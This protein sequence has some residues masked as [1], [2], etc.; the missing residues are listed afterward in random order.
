MIMLEI[1][2]NLYVFA[3]HSIMQP[4][5]MGLVNA[6]DTQH[7]L[8]GYNVSKLHRHF[9]GHVLSFSCLVFT[10]SLL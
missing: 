9:I 8:K 4:N 3:T 2:V 10:S 6:S 1:L 7:V 5:L